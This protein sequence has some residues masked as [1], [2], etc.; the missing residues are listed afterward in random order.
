MFVFRLGT[1]NPFRFDTVC[2]LLDW[3]PESFFDLTLYVCF[4]TGHWKAFRIDIV[5][6]FSDWALESFFEL[7]LYVFRLGTGKLFRFDTVCFQI[8]H[9]DF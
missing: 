6:L 3:A 9:S 4:Q 1:G 8:G 7:T 2:L 5:C